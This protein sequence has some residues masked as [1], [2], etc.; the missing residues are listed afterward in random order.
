MS[1]GTM[2]TCPGGDLGVILGEDDVA[3]SRGQESSS[4]VLPV[5]V[6]VQPKRVMSS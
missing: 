3:D 5:P 1:T 4:R 2:R 6:V